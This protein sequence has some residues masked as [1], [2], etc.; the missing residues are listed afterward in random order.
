MVVLPLC[1]A[2]ITQRNIEAFSFYDLN[3][4]INVYSVFVKDSQTRLRQTVYYV[5]SHL[6]CAAGFES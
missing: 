4:L 5:K 6:L 2:L 1:V 3:S